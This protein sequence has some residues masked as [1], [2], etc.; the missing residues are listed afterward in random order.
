[1]FN[2]FNMDSMFSLLNLFN[3]EWFKKMAVQQEEWLNFSQ[4]KP[5]LKKLL[6]L[7]NNLSKSS[8]RETAMPFNLKNLGFGDW[9][10][11]FGSSSFPSVQ[12][13]APKIGRSL[14]NSLFLGLLPGLVLRFSGFFL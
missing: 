2:M 5:S 11:W 7:A 1:M 12:S 8:S 10:K 13:F 6:D 14:L 4:N 9:E 3:D